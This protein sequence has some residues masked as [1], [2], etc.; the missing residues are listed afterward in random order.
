MLGGFYFCEKTL[1][2]V[3]R[4]SKIALILVPHINEIKNLVMSLIFQ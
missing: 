3:L 2:L 1:I 4:K